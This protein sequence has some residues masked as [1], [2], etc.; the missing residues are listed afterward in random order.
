MQD[1]KVTVADPYRTLP[2]R[3]SCR[4]QLSLVVVETYG[5]A[6]LGLGI[7]RVRLG[8][9]S[10]KWRDSFIRQ[11][12][13]LLTERG[14]MDIHAF[15]GADM[16]ADSIVMEKELFSASALAAAAGRKTVQSASIAGLP[17]KEGDDLTLDVRDKA[18]SAGD[19]L[20]FR[21]F[22]PEGREMNIRLALE[23]STHTEGVEVADRFRVNAGRGIGQ[24]LPEYGWG[25]IVEPIENFHQ[26]GIPRGWENVTAITLNVACDGNDCLLGNINLQKRERPEG[27]RLTDSG[28]LD[29]IDLESPGLSSVQEEAE[30]GR[31]GKALE[32]LA[33]YYA[34]RKKPKHIYE[35]PGKD[36]EYDTN[37]ADRILSHYIL[38]QQLPEKIDWRT[39]PIGY[40]EWMHSFNRHA[41]FM[42][43]LADAYFATGN[44]VY[45]REMDAL[46]NS[47]ICAN[48]VPLDHNGGGDPAWETLS[49]AV[50]I[51][52]VW[53]K[54]FFGLKDSRVFRHETRIMMLKS[55]Y[56][57]AEHLMQRSVTG[58]NNWLIVESQTLALTGMLFPEFKR[59]Q[60]WREEGWNR[61]KPCMDKQVFDDG[62]QYE[63]SSGYHMMAI[64]GFRDPY[65][66]ARMN[67]LEI[68]DGMEDM[69]QKAHAYTMNLCR[70]DLVQAKPN[71]S[72]SNNLSAADGN[73]W[74]ATG[75]KLFNRD[76]MIWAGTGGT[77]GKKPESGSVAFDHAGYYVMRSGWDRD[78]RWLF[79]DGASFGKAHH[80][81]DKLHFELYAYGEPLILDSAITG[82]MAGSWTG[83]YR[84]SRAHNTLL[85]DGQGQ[86][87]KRSE[88][89]EDWIA[90]SAGRNTWYSAGDVD[91]VESAYNSGYEDIQGA[92]SHTRAV[93]FLRKRH[94][95]I[96]DSMSGQGQHRIDAL[97]HFRPCRVTADP[98]H[99][100]L[101]TSR[102]EKTNVDIVT[103]KQA[104]EITMDIVCGQRNPVQGWISADSED[105]PAPCGII[106]KEGT[107]PLRLAYGV[108]PYNAGTR[109]GIGIEPIEMPEGLWAARLDYPDG[110]AD[111]VVFR[112]PGVAREAYEVAGHRSRADV[113]VVHGGRGE[114]EPMCEIDR[115]AEHGTRAYCGL[116]TPPSAS[117]S[118]ARNRQTCP[119]SAALTPPAS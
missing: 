109:S 20:V 15:A 61:L 63:L 29:L 115:K 14:I 103:W 99:R 60:D 91:F 69:L 6:P 56:E 94:W 37:Q 54:L 21:V 74:L 92:F 113:L 33:R 13:C 79:F 76:D 68:S 50:R 77:E 112:W 25:A 32:H 87:R 98:E 100:C 22:V 42:N 43:P 23:T 41:K 105:I 114:G 110:K 84:H 49:T 36:P 1:G 82:Y 47:W 18:M 53:L 39:N 2:S 55:F 106:S 4:R 35:P 34:E 59:A 12:Q 46:L 24:R 96:F 88:S 11:A 66:I 38:G 95:I 78:D 90:D 10:S 71:D 97:F 3:Q 89:M 70:P 5:T 72:G 7:E 48:P 65:R 52:G 80:H 73:A 27:P 75:G 83:Y 116:S 45:A 8:L 28:L 9:A 17:V 40:L 108:F 62:A 31:T 117:P 93:L 119:P 26:I 111:T 44:E 67:G 51:Y 30:A 107:L 64:S 118:S 104:G 81:E 57:H 102:Q 85:L 86:N 101:R 19:Q 58:E 16:V